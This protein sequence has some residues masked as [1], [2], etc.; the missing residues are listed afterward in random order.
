MSWRLQ[1]DGLDRSIYEASF[2]FGGDE[3][4]VNALLDEMFAFFSARV[5]PELE[6]SGATAVVFMADVVETRVFLMIGAREPGFETGA[7]DGCIAFCPGLGESLP[8]VGDSPAQAER[9]ADAARALKDLLE[10]GAHDRVVD[11]LN[12]VF[13]R[14]SALSFVT[15]DASE[16]E[17]RTEV[18][19]RGRQE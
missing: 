16:P 10:T 18:P 15:I 13:A 8:D 5:V 7:F 1:E 14:F 19:L 3:A 17:N 11:R 6:E 12:R 2:D 9:F 4:G